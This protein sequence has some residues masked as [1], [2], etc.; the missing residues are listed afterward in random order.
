MFRGRLIAIFAAFCAVLVVVPVSAEARSFGSR[1][2]K[3]GSSGGDVR[4]LQRYLTKVG[5]PTGADGYFG[6][7]TQRVVRSRRRRPARST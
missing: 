2:L 3:L 1:V 5:Y 6:R 4:T 7:G